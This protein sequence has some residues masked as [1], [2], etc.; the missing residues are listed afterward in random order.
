MTD[1]E[2]PGPRG[3]EKMSMPTDL[4]SGFSGTIQVDKLEAKGGE[5]GDEPTRLQGSGLF[6]V[7]GQAMPCHI[8]LVEV[9]M[10][11]GLETTVNPE[12][13]DYLDGLDLIDEGSSP[14]RT[15]NY[16]GREYIIVLWPFG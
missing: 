1:F 7:A 8:H 6:H 13:Q 16:K 9:W 5:S 2:H 10:E 3:A 14:R 15:I 12:D 4:F 11:D